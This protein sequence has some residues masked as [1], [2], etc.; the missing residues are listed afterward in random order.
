MVSARS[1]K[2][3]GSAMEYM[4][5]ETLVHIFDNLVLTKELGFV[6]Q[7]DLVDEKLSVAI[8]CKF[9]KSI[10]WN[11]AVKFFTKLENKAKEFEIHYLVF[12]YNQQPP[13]VMYRDDYAITV[14]QFE[15]YFGIP[16]V[17]NLIVKTH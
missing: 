15:D 13:L 14:K 10:S 16:L 6:R 1:A 11:Q 12:K 2:S 5:K 17:R 7:Y 8:E 3:K 4:T 9:H